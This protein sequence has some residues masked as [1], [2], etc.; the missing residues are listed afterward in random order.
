[1]EETKK[2]RSRSRFFVVSNAFSFSRS[3]C[4]FPPDLSRPSSSTMTTTTT[5]PPV[6]PV[7]ATKAASMEK[8]KER[9]NDSKRASFDGERN[10]KKRVEFFFF[11]CAR[12]PR[13]FKTS[14]IKKEEREKNAF[15]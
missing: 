4:S 14:K 5:E 6:R 11:S 7:E 9:K 3:F 2:L 10:E 15:T 8:M 13:K 12:P 1:M